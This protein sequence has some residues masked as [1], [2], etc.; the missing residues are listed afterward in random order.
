MSLDPAGSVQIKRTDLYPTPLWHTNLPTNNVK[1]RKVSLNEDLLNFIKEEYKKNPEIVSKSNKGGGWQSRTDLHKEPIMDELGN[2]IY[3]VCKTIFPQIK[4]M[5]ITQMWAAINFEHSYNL[6][7]CHGNMY[8]LSGAYYLQVPKDSGRIAFRDP[9][10]AAINHYWS[11]KQIDNGEHHWREP[12][13][14]DLMLWPTFLDHFVEPSKS[15][16]P[17]VMISFDLRFDV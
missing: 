3:N 12:Q 4:G 2:H 8:H 17:R 1:E 15:K 5:H 6:I 14:S 9:R 10:H 13:E 7:H 16:D 11:N